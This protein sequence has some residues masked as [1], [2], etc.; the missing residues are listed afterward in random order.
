MPGHVFIAYHPRDVE[1]RDRL[2]ARLGAAGMDVWS[3]P[4]SAY[5][6]NWLTVVRP[7]IDSCGV[8]V[9][10]MTQRAE[11]SDWIDRQ[12]ARAIEIGVPIRPLLLQGQR[13]FKR[14]HSAALRT[15]APPPT[16]A[17][18]FTRVLDGE[19]P[20]Q[21]YV[22]DLLAAI[23]RPPTSSPATTPPLDITPAATLAL[24][25]SQIDTSGWSAAELDILA[26]VADLATWS[27]DGSTIAVAGDDGVTHLWDVATRAVRTTIAQADRVRV[28]NW[29]P[30]GAS[31]VTGDERVAVR[32]WDPTGTARFRVPASSDDAC[33]TAW[34][35]DGTVLATAGHGDPSVR[36]W[37]GY[38]GEAVAVLAGHRR[39]QIAGG[40]WSP[41]EPHLL[42]VLGDRRVRL[43][44]TQAQTVRAELAPAGSYGAAWSPDGQQ[45]AT[46]LDEEI[47]LWDVD[48]SIERHTLIDRGNWPRCVAWSPD[49]RRLAAGGTDATVRIW[50]AASPHPLLVLRGHSR[51]VFSV[52]WS[53]DGQRLVTAGADRTPHLWDIP[54]SA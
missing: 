21:P 2:A 19:M 33:L 22:D 10:L 18:L 28:V 12:V 6:T 23:G 41:T 48:A 25:P 53:A 14:L 32:V 44:D 9:V 29:S 40:A 20:R 45:L 34:S 17:S 43:W 24:P 42:A 5:G 26:P 8:F 47:G 31:L 3:E 37:N 1:Y 11:A 51:A 15:G 27:P 36:L 4:R 39:W 35:S 54:A 16:A 49:G 38:T 50:D 7:K 13:A 52:S 46:L 30:D